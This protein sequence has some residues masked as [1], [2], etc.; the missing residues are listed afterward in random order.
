MHSRPHNSRSVKKVFG[1]MCKD[2]MRRRVGLRRSHVG[3]VRP[4]FFS[5]PPADRRSP[6]GV[7]ARVGRGGLVG[8]NMPLGHTARIICTPITDAGL[9]LSDRRSSV[10]SCAQD[11]HR[12]FVGNYIPLGT[13][14]ISFR[15]HITDC[16]VHIHSC[17]SCRNWSI[18]VGVISRIV[19]TWKVSWNHIRHL[20]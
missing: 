14:V 18:T 20:R 1:A 4:W 7:R 15:A 13:T 3:S 2:R 17:S 10:G 5:L 11:N 16:I 9:P 8:N 12:C 19:D 6:V